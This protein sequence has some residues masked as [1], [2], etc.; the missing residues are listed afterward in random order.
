MPT[1][2]LRLKMVATLAGIISVS[3]LIFTAIFMAIGGPGSNLTYFAMYSLGFVIFIHFIQWL[4]GPYIIEAIYKVKPLEDGAYSWLRNIVENLALRSG[5]GAAPPIMVS[6]IDVPNAFAYGNAITG[7]KVAVTSGLLKNLPP[8]EVEAVLGHELGHIKH[9]DVELMM[10]ISIIPALMLWLGRVLM[11][12]GMFGERDRGGY[13]ALVGIA[14]I[15]LSFVFN[16]FVLYVSRLREYYADSHSAAVVPDGATKLQRALARIMLVSGELKKVAP[17]A[18]ASS[19][20]LK[21]FFIADPEEG[22]VIRHPANI[23]E[24]VEWIK[25]QERLLPVEAFSTHPDPAKRLRFLDRFKNVEP[26]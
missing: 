25:S 26:Y 6:N 23:D 15:A 19:G 7:Y 21:A 3:T 13:T 16:L 14:V 9:R 24:V 20:K 22:L 2:K 12:S 17:E 18:I 10:V 11:W 5:L 4:L 1:T 8:D